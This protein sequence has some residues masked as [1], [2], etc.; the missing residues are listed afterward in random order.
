[1]LGSFS[2]LSILSFRHLAFCL[3]ILNHWLAFLFQLWF[4][5]S[6]FRFHSSRIKISLL[7]AQFQ[8]ISW[9]AQPL[10]VSIIIRF[11]KVKIQA[12]AFTVI[13]HLRLEVGFEHLSQKSLLSLFIS[14]QLLFLSLL[15]IS[16]VS[17]SLVLLEP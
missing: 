15:L 2:H 10:F 6:S 8:M 14:V 7:F 11:F 9:L 13:K 4:I 16:L 5:Q 17:L 3:L 12:F 1:M